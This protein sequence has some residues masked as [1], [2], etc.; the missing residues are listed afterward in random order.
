[1]RWI[2]NLLDSKK[3]DTAVVYGL[4]VLFAILVSTGLMFLLFLSDG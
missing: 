3:E 1:M 4:S 2:K